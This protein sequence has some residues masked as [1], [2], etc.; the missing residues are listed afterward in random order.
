MNPRIAEVKFGNI[1]RFRDGNWF[2]GKN[3][4]DN[5]IKTKVISENDIKRLLSQQGRVLYRN[6]YGKYVIKVSPHFVDD[7]RANLAMA[8]WIEMQKK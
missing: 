8:Q 2:Y 1:L 6:A 5:A 3:T 7:L 4:V